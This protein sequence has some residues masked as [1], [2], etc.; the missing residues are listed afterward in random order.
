MIPALLLSLLSLSGSLSRDSLD[1]R[2]EETHQL[3]A[4]LE[5]RQATASE[6]LLAIRDH[7]EIARDYYNELAL[8]ETE[9]I[10]TLQYISERYFYEDS[11]RADLERGLAAYVRYIYSH[12]RLTSRGS[13]FG[14]EG[15]SRMLRRHA[16]LD[17][18]ASRAADQFS[19]LS[20]SSDSLAQY[21]DSLETLRD[22]IRDLR[23]RMQEIQTR[24][25]GEEARQ[26][27][28]RLQLESEIEIAAESAAAIE[29]QRQQLSRFVTG[30]RTTT[31]TSSAD[32]SLY[33]PVEP[34]S[35]SFLELERGSISWPCRGEVVRWFGIVTDP[36]YGTETACDGVRVATSSDSGIRSVGSGVVLFASEFPNRGQMVIIDHQDGYYTIY[37]NL[38]S[39]SVGQSDPVEE[40]Q[41]L[42]T[43]GTI[44]EGRSGYHFEIRRAGQ[45]VDPV[46][47]LEML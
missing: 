12:R 31:S 7:L 34:S 17:Y 2:L 24:I 28:L 29:Q 35:N 42:G 8:R 9:V 39:L 15:L 44:P 45:P 3:I 4:A 33:F 47:Y 5:A 30:L 13:V 14:S 46:S 18:L 37:A 36:E 1:T 6:I 22:D 21:R 16:Y 23:E 26:T 10:Q 19:R 11:V 40:G 43:C 38:G 25:Y 41:H 32:G 20:T 27:A